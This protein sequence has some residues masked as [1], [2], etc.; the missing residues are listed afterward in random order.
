MQ[1]Y[2]GIGTTGKAADL[3]M[4][5]HDSEGSVLFRIT[6][7]YDNGRSGQHPVILSKEKVKQLIADLVLIL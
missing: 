2:N 5:R 4:E 1:K 3:K 7:Y 6:E